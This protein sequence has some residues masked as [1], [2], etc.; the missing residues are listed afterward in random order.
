[1]SASQRFAE[2]QHPHTATKAPGQSGARKSKEAPSATGRHGGD[3]DVGAQRHRQASLPDDQS[4]EWQ[5][6]ACSRAACGR[7][8]I[9]ATQP[10]NTPGLEG[11]NKGHP[12]CFVL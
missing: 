10:C 7:K 4:P 1:M 9:G 6:T 5:S 12:Y 3:G 2:T 8:A 11:P